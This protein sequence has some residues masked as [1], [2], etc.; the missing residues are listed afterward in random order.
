[1]V[2]VAGLKQQLSGN[3]AETRPT[4]CRRP[5]SSPP[6]ARAPTRWWRTCTGIWRKDIEPGLARVGIRRVAPGELT[7]E[8]KAHLSALLRPRGLAGADAAGGRPRAPVPDAAQPQPQPGGVPAPR[9]GEGRPAR[10][11]GRGGAGPVGAAALIE[12]PVPAA[13]P[14]GNVRDVGWQ[15]R[16]VRPG[17]DAL[18]VHAARG[19]DHH[20]RGRSVPRLPRARLQPVPGH[21]Q[22]RPL[23]ST[24]TRPTICSRPSRRSCG[25]ASA[26][27][28]CGWR[29]PTTRPSRSSVFLRQALRLETDDVYLFDGPLHLADL[30]P[31]GGARRPARVPRRAVLAA[32]RAAAAGVRRHLPRHRPARHP[33]APPVRVVRAR[34]R[35]HRRGGRRPQRAGHQADAVPD[36]RR[37][38]H[39]AGADPRRRERQAGD[40]ASS[41]SRPA[42]TRRP[43]SQWARTLEEAGVHVVYG[44]IGLKTHCKVA[45]VVRREGNR[46]KRYVHL[47]TGNYNPSTARLYGDLS[48]FTARDAFADDAGRAV[49]PADRLFVAAVVEAVRGRARSACRSGS[50]SSSSARRR[51]GSRGRI[52]AKMNSLVDPQ[53]IQAL[54]RASQA[55]VSI[56]LHRARHLLPAPG[57]ARDQRQHPRASASSTASS[58]TRASSISATAASARSTCRRPTGCRATSSAASR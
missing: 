1:M 37:F 15:Q 14:G 6:S 42:S 56:D 40:R 9:E 53:V 33:A 48:Y 30:A 16:G 35:V 57:R 31:L 8:Q 12:V 5:S 7:P 20:A 10:D 52:I 34:G 49:Q 50:S 21:P 26:A 4:A 24:R 18:R 46:I 51:C 13:R 32:D 55:G 41:S 28:R 58:S 43:T 44:L 47:S 3:V 45:L 23:A 27:A 11:H 25:A 38:A 17:H 19:P 36:Q 22:L 39:R 2:R 29:S 54:Y